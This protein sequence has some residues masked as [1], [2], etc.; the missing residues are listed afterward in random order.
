LS[1][2]SADGSAAD[3]FTVWVDARLW[4]CCGDV[5]SVGSRVHMD[6]HEDPA[7]DWLA[8]RLPPGVV[9]RVTHVED[10]HSFQPDAVDTEGVVLSISAALCR[11]A[12]SDER[13]RPGPG[14]FYA[15]VAGSAALQQWRTSQGPPGTDLAVRGGLEHVGYLV[16]LRVRRPTSREVPSRH[17][18]T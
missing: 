8:E 4:A 13:P 2:G 18:A 15:P 7:P 1:D 6:L 14:R 17:K 3:L 10:H 12:P 9:D 16:E 5:F 11:Y